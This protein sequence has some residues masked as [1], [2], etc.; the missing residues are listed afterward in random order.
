MKDDII[1]NKSE[2]IKRCFDRIN[3]E[4]ASDPLNLTNFTKQDSIILNIQR[5]CESCLDIA[6]HIIRVKQLEI[7]QISKEGF[8][9]LEKNKIIDEKLSLSLQR[10]VGFRNIAVHNYQNL[11]LDIVQAVIENHIQDPM[12]FIHVILDY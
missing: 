1:I 11:N 8:Q 10:M 7:P 3:E 6:M 12:R 5:M 4:Y 2:T 9:I